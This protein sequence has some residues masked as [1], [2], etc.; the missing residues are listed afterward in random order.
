VLNKSKIMQEL[1]K[2]DKELFVGFTEEIDCIAQVW[3][4]ISTDSDFFQ[5]I[6]DKHHA[7]LVPY[8]QGLLGLTFQIP[9]LD[10]G[11][12]VLS[13]DGSQIYYDKHQ[14]PP[15]FLINTGFMQL[16]YNLPGQ[17]VVYGNNPILE[18]S[19]SVK[20]DFGSAD[21]V[22]MQR[23]AFEFD[24]ALQYARLI[25]QELP[26][27]LS[28]TLFDGSLIFFH[29]DTQS[30]EQKSYF[31]KYYC[32][33]LEKFYCEKM[34]IAGYISLPKSKELVNL[35]SLELSQGCSLEGKDSKKID[36]LTDVD[37]ADLYL[38]HGQRSIVFKSKAPISYLYPKHV[39]PYFCYL[40]VGSEIV[41]LEFPAWIG[42]DDAL[43]D[44]I[45]FVALDQA[46]KGMGYPVVLF[47]AHEQAVIKSADR[48]FFYA[49]LENLSQKKSKHYTM[50]QKS[51]K[52]QRPLV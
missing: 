13:V 23:E 9:I 32:D 4:K 43:V 38:K 7:L 44:T 33:I 16:R 29:L 24:S 39:Q 37:I 8:W 51:I 20:N 27:Q 41:R 22:D 10:L 42:V 48:Y 50:S 30:S 46:K 11:Y 1:Q 5:K 40:H 36:R 31:L 12:T 47:E 17:S 25:A 6:N 28:V 14:G 18:V 49:M 21:F 2:V 26:D 3:H 15:C 34:L 19:L 35:C 52:K 45:C